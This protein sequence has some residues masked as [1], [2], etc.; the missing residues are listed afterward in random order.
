MNVTP[1]LPLSGLIKPKAERQTRLSLSRAGEL[2]PPPP[3]PVHGPLPAAPS[4]HLP[5][6]INHHN[7]TRFTPCREKTKLLSDRAR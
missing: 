1:S 2:E 5:L 3:P 6:T 4:F 7:S